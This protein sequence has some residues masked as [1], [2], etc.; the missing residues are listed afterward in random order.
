[1]QIQSGR[2]DVGRVLLFY[3]CRNPEEDYMYSDAELKEWN[4]IG[5]VDIRPAF[6]RAKELSEGCKYVQERILHDAADIDAFFKQGAKFF[7]CGGSNVAQGI[8]EAC[9]KLI[10]KGP[11]MDYERA[12][13][14]FLRIQKERYATD[15][16][17]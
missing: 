6:S 5:A 11:D 2:Q 13:E 9:I 4:A 10:Q 1:M 3:G 15:I 7:T 17:G 16:F 14:A 8:K 12:T